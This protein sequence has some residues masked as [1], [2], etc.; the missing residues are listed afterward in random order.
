VTLV[1]IA[2][3][4]R[5]ARPPRWILIDIFIFH[6]VERRRCSVGPHPEASAAELSS[7]E[8][9]HHQHPIQIDTVYIACC[10]DRERVHSV[11]VDPRRNSHRE[12]AYPAIVHR[13]EIERIGRVYADVISGSLIVGHRGLPGSEYESRVVSGFETHG[14]RQREGV[15]AE[16]TVRNEPVLGAEPYDVT[17]PRIGISERALRRIKRPISFNDIPRRSVAPQILRRPCGNDEIGN[18]DIRSAVPRI[19][20]IARDVFGERVRWDD[21]EDLNLSVHGHSVSALRDIH[22][23]MIGLLD[24]QRLS[25]VGPVI[26]IAFVGKLRVETHPPFGLGVD[27]NPWPSG[28]IRVVGAMQDIGPPAGERMDCNVHFKVHCVRKVNVS[29]DGT[30]CGVERLHFAQQHIVFL[31]FEERGWFHRWIC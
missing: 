10:V 14:H 30:R 17:V 12:P 9:C 24:L 15:V 16:V 20:C 1:N 6:R 28:E 19:G 11:K 23:P 27:P 18:G 3:L 26:Q 7:G 21:I 13:A 5:L 4:V 2:L 22:L 29:D 25:S 8:I 31:I